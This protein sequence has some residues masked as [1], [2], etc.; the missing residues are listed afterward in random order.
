M[1]LTFNFFNVILVAGALSSCSKPQKNLQPENAQ[2]NSAKGG[3]AI[4]TMAGQTINNDAFWMDSAGDTIFAQ[5]GC[6]IKGHLFFEVNNH[7]N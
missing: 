5:G 6:I 1:K 3:Y 2:L 7:R 4:S